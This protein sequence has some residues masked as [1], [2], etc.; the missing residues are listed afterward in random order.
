MSFPAGP[1]APR[2]VQTAEWIG[3]PIQLMERC[4][5]LYGDMFT[6]R[7]LGIGKAVFVYQSGGDQAGLHGQARA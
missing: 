4:A 3:R 7:M 1:K 6:L 5:R 2:A